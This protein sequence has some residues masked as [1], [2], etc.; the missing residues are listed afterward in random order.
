MEHLKPITMNKSE[1][2]TEKLED[3]IERGLVVKTQR[4][5]STMIHYRFT[6]VYPRIQWYEED[7]EE[8]ERQRQA[9]LEKAEE[10][11]EILEEVFPNWLM[12]LIPARIYNNSD[13]RRFAFLRRKFS[14]LYSHSHEFGAIV[15]NGKKCKECG[16]TNTSG[17]STRH[18]GG[19]LE[20]WTD[21]YD[22][23]SSEYTGERF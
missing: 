22:C 2:M 12:T 20:S 19:G 6:D 11:D 15:K 1:Y 9:I 8:I 14:I 13:T 23:E 16:S 3:L 7:E 21:C 17:R 4:E 18:Y 10:L 5:D